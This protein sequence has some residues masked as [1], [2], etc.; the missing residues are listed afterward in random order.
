M[1]ID[2]TSKTR[3]MS[4]RLKQAVRTAKTMSPER[5]VGVLVRAGLIRKGDAPKAIKN[6]RK[7]RR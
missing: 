3:T 6:M 5:R 7:R 4:T 2:G 1:K